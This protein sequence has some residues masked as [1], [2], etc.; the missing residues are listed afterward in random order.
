MIQRK[1]IKDHRTSTDY[2]D[3]DWLNAKGKIELRKQFDEMIKDVS[4][5]AEFELHHGYEETRLKITSYRDETDAEMTRRAERE[6]RDRE[7]KKAARER[8]KS[9]TKMAELKQLRALITKYKGQVPSDG[10]SNA[11]N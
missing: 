8:M 5:D 6:K 4:D 11:G 2:G 9:E 1:R 3:L 7:R 10:A